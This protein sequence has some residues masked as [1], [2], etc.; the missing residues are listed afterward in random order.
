[1]KLDPG[2]A[3]L[4]ATA[5]S[6]LVASATATT[7]AKDVAKDVLYFNTWRREDPAVAVAASLDMA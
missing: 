5:V 2:G 3:M 1:M 6:K 4:K 7:T